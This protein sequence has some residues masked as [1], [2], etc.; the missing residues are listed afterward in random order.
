MSMPFEIP[1]TIQSKI[2]HT[3]STCICIYTYVYTHKIQ[4]LIT[5]KQSANER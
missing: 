1:R 5:Q 4:K 2:R 3:L